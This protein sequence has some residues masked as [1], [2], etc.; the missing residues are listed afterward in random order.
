MGD[1]VLQI[2]R[3]HY[4]KLNFIFLGMPVTFSICVLEGLLR[5]GIRPSAIWMPDSSAGR[6]IQKL[7]PELSQSELPLLRPFLQEGIAQLAWE[8][9]IPVYAVRDLSSPDAIALLESL[10]V[11]VGIV[12]CFPMRLPQEILAIPRF[13]FLNLHPSLLPAYRGPF[14]L[15]WTFRDG[16]QESGITMHQIDRGLDTGDIVL[17]S[18]LI[19][20]DGLN[21]KEADE[22][23]AAEGATLIQAALASLENG[24]LASQAQG[25][26]ASY[27]GRP[28][29][30]DFTIPTTWTAQRAFNFM[31]GTAEWQMP[32]RITGDGFDI[33]AR[34]AIAYDGQGKMDMPYSTQGSESWIKFERG[35]LYV[36]SC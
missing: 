35:I 19:I 4:P 13:S 21:S 9:K 29:A 24:D 23:F 32:Y 5:A 17:Q 11:S 12:A 1:V 10:H 16:V 27:F 31:R 25:T 36:S 34:S 28:S 26:G 3:M 2:Q 18:K 15:F 22:L 33:P 30:Q 20:P 14:P 7:Q 6:S 8:E